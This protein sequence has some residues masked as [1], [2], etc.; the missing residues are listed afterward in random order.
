MNVD[1]KYNVAYMDFDPSRHEDEEQVAKTIRHEMFHIMHGHFYLLRD[2][3]KFFVEKNE[4]D[5]LEDTFDYCAE[6]FVLQMERLA[7]AGNL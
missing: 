5:A 7:D 2:Q 3:I 6:Q 1:H 4:Y